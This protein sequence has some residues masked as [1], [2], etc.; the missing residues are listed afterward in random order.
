MFKITYYH[1]SRS[2]N[3][4][5][6]Q[7]RH[8]EMRV[9]CVFRIKP[10]LLRASLAGRLLLMSVLDASSLYSTAAGNEGWENGDLWLMFHISFPSVCATDM[11]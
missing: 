8:T 2:L 3:C 1:L 10:P 9:L 5:K 11:T 6:K 7:S 4:I